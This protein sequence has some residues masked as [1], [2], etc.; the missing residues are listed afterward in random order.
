M[1]TVT[2]QSLAVSISLFA[3]VSA[4]NNSD[5]GV[6]VP[7]PAPQPAEP[8][9]IS[10]RLA[11]GDRALV[12]GDPA[13]ARVEFEAI[14]NDPEARW[15]DKARA[16][17][18]LSQ[19]F[20]AEGN[21]EGAV[22]S[23]EEALAQAPQTNDR[24]T[25]D[26]HDRLF[27]LLRGVKEDSFVS[28]FQPAAPVASF[29]KTLLSV[30]PE[31][32]EPGPTEIAIQV[33][34]SVPSE[35]ADALGLFDVSGAMRAKK[36]EACGLCTI[37]SNVHTSRNRHGS[38]TAIASDRERIPNALTVIY[39]DLEQNLVPARYDEFLP[40]PS[41]EIEKRLADGAGFYAIEDRSPAPPIILLAAP[42]TA[43]LHA[44]EDALAKATSWPEAPVRVPV[45]RGFTR[46]EIQ[47]RVRTKRDAFRDCYTEY[48]TRV[49]AASIRASMAF[50]ITPAGVV[51][52]ARTETEPKDEAFARCMTAAATTM[53]FGPH[54]ASTTVRYPIS[55]AP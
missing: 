34:G 40:L 4:C 21:R 17:L 23:I 27:L 7:V 5:T 50:T 38:W 43:Q 55:F 28:P 44:V 3:L 24:V 42:R 48:L 53:R 2:R 26:L 46:E 11:A 1:K 20:E 13:G 47:G 45:A 33:Y 52:D 8:S 6:P 12:G 9:S 18:G 31:A 39:F 37:K 30:F 19:A 16:R 32:P 49:P 29:A 54:G 36:Q 10:A 14:V 22:A 41:A 25:G 15:E 51:T 35:H